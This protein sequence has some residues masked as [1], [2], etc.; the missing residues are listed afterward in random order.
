MENSRK[1]GQNDGAFMRN[2]KTKEPNTEVTHYC[3]DCG[4]RLHI[5]NKKNEFYCLCDDGYWQYVNGF[6]KWV[7]NHQ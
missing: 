6:W 5:G 4:Q 2:R 1:R 7:T 3:P